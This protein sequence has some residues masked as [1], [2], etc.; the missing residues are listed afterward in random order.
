MS[1]LKE[2]MHPVHVVLVHFPS[3]LYPFSLVMDSLGIYQ[4]NLSFSASAYYALLFAFLSSLLAALFGIIDYLKIQAESTAFRTASIHGALNVL[5]MFGFAVAIKLRY[6]HFN[7]DEQ[8]SMIYIFTLTVLVIGM[9]FSNH[10][11]GDLVFRHRIG[12][13]KSN[14]PIDTKNR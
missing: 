5:W 11:G 14:P 9:A 7:A 10:L 13:K 4:S 6:N 8:P 12:A 3:A 2:K 1:R